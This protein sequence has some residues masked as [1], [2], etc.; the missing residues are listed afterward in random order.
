MLDD[1]SCWA[2]LWCHHVRTNLELSYQGFSHHIHSKCFWHWLAPVVRSVWQHYGET[3]L[4]NRTF[5]FVCYYCVCVSL[6]EKYCGQNIWQQPVGPTVYSALPL[7]HPRLP[8]RSLFTLQELFIPFS[9]MRLSDDIACVWDTITIRTWWCRTNTFRLTSTV[10]GCRLGSSA[11][12]LQ[13][14]TQDWTT[15]RNCYSW[16]VSK[17]GEIWSRLKNTNVTLWW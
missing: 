11:A 7:V 3:L 17:R 4:R 2:K 14:L 15:F 16:L 12:C 9:V 13:P 8:P 10:S 6:K 5:F 1:K